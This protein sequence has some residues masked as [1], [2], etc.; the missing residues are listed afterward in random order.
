MR[1]N[2]RFRDLISI[3]LNAAKNIRKSGW[4]INNIFKW[5]A[6]NLQFVKVGA[7]SFHVQRF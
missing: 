5:I 1:K 3:Y 7:H 4:F 2:H 6:E